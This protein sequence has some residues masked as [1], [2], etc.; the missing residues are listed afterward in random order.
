MFVGVRDSVLCAPRSPPWCA[1]LATLLSQQRAGY[2]GG[3]PRQKRWS[4]ATRG[5]RGWAGSPCAR[6]TSALHAVPRSRVQSTRVG[7]SIKYNRSDLHDYFRVRSSSI[8]PQN[9]EF[10]VLLKHRTLEVS[11][12]FRGSQPR[13]RCGS[14]SRASAPR[15][16]GAD[17]CATPAWAEALASL[18]S[19]C[20][21]TTAARARRAMSCPRGWRTGKH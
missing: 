15:R 20:T 3:R 8:N 7:P 2:V 18:G 10:E 19:G 1:P 6:L 11:E 12:T 9:F 16:R 21:A 5:W 13:P 17:S 14:D 4:R